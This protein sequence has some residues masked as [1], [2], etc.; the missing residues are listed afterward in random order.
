MSTS[1]I[2]KYAINANGILDIRED[3]VG[4]ELTDT[5]EWIDFKDLLSEMNGRT[6][7]LSVN[8]Y[9]EFGSNIK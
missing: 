8:C 7:T 9:E 6:I 1:I 2:K 4:V 5:G 3:S